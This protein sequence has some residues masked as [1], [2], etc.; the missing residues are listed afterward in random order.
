[1]TTPK[2]IRLES[3]GT[4][5]IDRHPF[6]NPHASANGFCLRKV[7]Y[8]SRKKAHKA[9]VKILKE[10][11]YKTHMRIYYCWNCAGYH[12]TKMSEEEFKCY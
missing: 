4:R 10:S 8:R 2:I 5:P 6:Y 9:Y 3:I 1:M 7:R 11:N 12:L